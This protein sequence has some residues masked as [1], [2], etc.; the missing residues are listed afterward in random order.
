MLRGGSTNWATP[1]PEH[2]FVGIIE[3]LLR[4]N[5][6]DRSLFGDH[7]ALPVGGSSEQSTLSTRVLKGVPKAKYTRNLKTS[8]T[9]HT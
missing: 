5:E 1:R 3:G 8:I 7:R 6:A 4:A 9:V 2:R